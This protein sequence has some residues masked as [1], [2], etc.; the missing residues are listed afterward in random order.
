MLNAGKTSADGQK[1]NRSRGSRP[2]IE[3]KPQTAYSGPM[4]TNF[5][6]FPLLFRTM[7]AIT[8]TQ[9]D[10][11]ET[12]LNTLIE[13]IASYNPSIPAANALLAADDDLN[14]GLK[15]RMNK[16]SRS[17]RPYFA[18]RCFTFLHNLIHPTCS[19]HPPNKSRP[20]SI[21]PLYHRPAKR[22][23][24]RHHHNPRL[25]PRRSA[26]YAVLPSAT[27]CAQRPLQRAS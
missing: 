9:L 19:I 14:N 22:I 18:T 23:H 2:E 24:N 13:S 27:G 6:A 25:H 17:Q 7:N 21:P 26:L 10:R 15:Q 12:A 4:S 5:C 11:V 1:S 20:H 3:T 8:Q 16:L